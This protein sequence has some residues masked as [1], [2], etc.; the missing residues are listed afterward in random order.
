MMNFLLLMANGDAANRAQAFCDKFSLA[1]TVA[2]YVVFVIKVIV[3]I[4]LII[5][6]ML[7]LAKAV[8]SGDEKK[9]K[10]AQATLIR[11]VVLAVSVFLVI[12]VVGIIMGLVS[13]DAAYKQCGKCVFSP[14]SKD[15]TF[16]EPTSDYTN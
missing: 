14:F 15:C 10:E 8:P 2:G 13:S 9:T 11:K 3:P 6:G 16:I 4:I 12:Q 5:T 1:F 7:T